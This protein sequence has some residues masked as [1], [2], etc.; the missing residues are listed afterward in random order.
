M[1]TG[2][3]LTILAPSALM[4]KVLGPSADYVGEGIQQWT[5]RRVQNVN[6]VFLRAAE[7]LG[8]ERLEQE[9]SVPP[10]VLKGILEEAPFCDDELCAEYLGGALATARAGTP[11]DDR[12]TTLIALVAGLSTYQIRTHYVMYYSAQRLLAER[13]INLG[14][15]QTR[16][17]HGAF[18]L[19]DSLWTSGMDFSEEERGKELFPSIVDHVV[20]GL[21]REELIDNRMLGTGGPGYLAEQFERDFPEPGI[22][23]R[24]SMLGLELFT[25]AHGM[26]GRP[27]LCF[28]GS[29]KQFQID[30]GLD[31]DGEAI[32]LSELPVLPTGDSS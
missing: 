17:Q 14:D 23:F 32:S 21:S 29:S 19:P 30:K 22:V 6:R 4:L 26:A 12:A 3:G 18:F 1:D 11:R 2:T 16:N 5:E 28:Q 8:P 25:A 27:A 13:D 15:Q 7:K 9:G 24:I 31:L 10:R 20:Y